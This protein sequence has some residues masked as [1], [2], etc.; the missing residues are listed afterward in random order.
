MKRKRT[1]E[2]GERTEKDR[3]SDLPDEVL[4]HIMEFLPTRQ[5]IQTCVLSKRW[6]NLW[7]GITTLHFRCTNGIRKYNRY[8]IHVLSNRYDSISLRNMNFRVFSSTAPKVM[9]KAIEYAS[10][11][12]LQ[13]LTLIIMDIKFKEIPSS[14]LPFVFN[15]KS[16]TSLNLYA[17]SSSSPLIFPPYL[18]LPF[19]KTLHLSNVTFKPRDDN[20]VEPFSGCTSLT[21]LV[22]EHSMRTNSS[23][24][25]CI[26]NPTISILRMQSIIYW[27]TFQPK[28]VLSL[29]KLT[30]ITLENI[31]FPVCYKLTCTCDL[32]LLKEVKIDNRVH[33]DSSIIVNWL[34]MFSNVRTLIIS[35]R[36]LKDLH[37]DPL[38]IQPP[39]FARL[40]LFKIEMDSRTV[41]SKGALTKVVDYFLRN[42]QRR[43]VNVSADSYGHVCSF[44]L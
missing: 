4:Q 44:I 8:I 21:T 13:E 22:L 36:T 25:L 15:C 1:N 33:V 20:N 7:K 42:C 31:H 28:I 34:Q 37:L 32:P 30:S 27:H 29:P 10:L 24:T 26:S 16:L 14:S 18:P 39:Y 35:S 5:A 23:Y 41:L 12:N 40:E 2:S 43:N 9:N 17:R 19:L 3:L 6:K 11:H 38:E